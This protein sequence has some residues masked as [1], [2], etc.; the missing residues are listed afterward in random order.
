MIILFWLGLAACT[1]GPSGGSTAGGLVTFPHAEGFKAGALHGKEAIAVGADACDTCHRLDGSAAPTCAS[2]HDAYPHPDGWLAGAVHGKGLTGDTGPVAREPCMKC[3]D[4][5]GL[6]A[7]DDHACTGCHASYPHVE[8]WELVGQHGTFML[9]RGSAG[10]AC[11]ACHGAD[12]AG[13][14]EAPSCTKCHVDYPHVQ[15]WEDPT[16]H[17]AAGLLRMDD[18]L[19]CHGDLG[20]GGTTGVACARC[21]PSFPHPADWAKTHPG[22]V[23]TVG[24]GPCSA[25][26][27]AGFGPPTMIARCAK[28]CH[29]GAQ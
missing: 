12:L 20:A 10:A 15:G 18:C 24:E 16:V 4:L 17:G 28:T 13:T 19:A 27:E 29:G 1:A 25:C 3:H 23:A 2:C 22:T 5:P 21:H 6:A 11:G 9:A 14:T 7:T 8:G 26:H